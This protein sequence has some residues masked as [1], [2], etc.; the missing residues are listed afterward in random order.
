MYE[1]KDYN[2]IMIITWNQLITLLPILIIGITVVIIM[3]SILY[4]RNHCRHVL[5]SIVGLILASI[6]LFSIIWKN[7]DIQNI[8]QIIY[9]DNYS[10]L[11]MILIIM[12][13]IIS[14]LLAYTWLSRYP[15]NYRDEFYLLLLISTM[16]GILLTVTNH[17][18]ILFLGIELISIP[19]LG[20]ISY[21]V[22]EKTSI[23]SSVKYI[24]LSGISSAFLLFG[25]ALIYAETGC[26][27]FFDIQEV[28]LNNNISNEEG[29]IQSMLLVMMGL[30]M[31]MVGFGFKLSSVPFHTWIPDIYQ[32]SPSVVSMYLSISSKIAVISVLIRFLLVLPEQYYSIF[33]MILSGL[34][35]CSMLFGSIV[36][37]QQDSIKRILAYSS[38]TS[39]GY[40]LM[41]L[42]LSRIDYS[43][44]QE[45]IGIYLINY[46]FSNVGAFG[47]ISLISMIFDSDKEVDTLSSY[48]GLFW[49][50]PTLSV[51]FTIIILSLAGIPMT[52]GF[53][54]KFYLLLN[55]VHNQLW[56]LSIFV[57][58]SSI[59]SI[60]YYLKIII[61][62][63]SFPMNNKK[64]NYH[65]SAHCFYNPTGIMIIVVAVGIIVFGIY[66]QFIISLIRLICI[67]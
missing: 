15:I 52:L 31:M 7:K 3:L 23:F 21:T 17:L 22:F 12:S 59:I 53:I 62:L 9:A 34:A 40:L 5:L 51:I 49:Y 25:I 48:K 39:S 6:V 1:N 61:N 19:L 55:G 2:G 37:I 60:F 42:I 65:S 45:A 38:I 58:I 44:S 56:M 36:A 63:Y 66:P 32:R 35:C 64:F 13:G 26:L 8:N 54:G 28:L 29:S 10:I 46:L 47:V 14:S 67:N 57:L 18:I 27:L 24:I 41:I 11:Y 43:M 16:G 50:N 20:L 4:R 30:V 33:Y